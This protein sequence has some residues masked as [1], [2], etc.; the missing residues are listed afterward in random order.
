MATVMKE[1]VFF[2]CVISDVARVFNYKLQPAEK[3]YHQARASWETEVFY[4]ITRKNPAGY[5]RR[6]RIEFLCNEAKKYANVRFRSI[7][8]LGEKESSRDIRLASG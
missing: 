8:E 3:L 2:S 5:T 1:G 4:I 6:L 7:N